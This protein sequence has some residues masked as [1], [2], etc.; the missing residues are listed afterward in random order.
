MK[1][2]E[3]V[4]SNLNKIY[5]FKKKRNDFKL[6]LAIKLALLIGLCNPIYGSRSFTNL[7]NFSVRI[8]IVFVLRRTQLSQSNLYAFFMS[9]IVDVMLTRLMNRITPNLRLHSIVSAHKLFK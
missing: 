6:F 5:E 9:S 2:D 3:L 4:D 7:N 1:S 8:N